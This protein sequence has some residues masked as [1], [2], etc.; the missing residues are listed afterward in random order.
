MV[1]T[2]SEMQK[3]MAWFW[4]SGCKDNITQ[5]HYHHHHDISQSINMLKRAYGTLPVSKRIMWRQCL[6]HPVFFDINC[7]FGLKSYVLAI[8]FMLILPRE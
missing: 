4:F 2:A 3:M 5:Y 8:P 1:C 7:L 6:Q